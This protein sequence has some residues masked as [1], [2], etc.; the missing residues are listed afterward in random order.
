M[1]SG[2][3]LH[4]TACLN[5]TYH[6]RPPLSTVHSTRFFLV[7]TLPPSSLCL[8]PSTATAYRLYCRCSKI[9][10]QDS[11]RQ[12]SSVGRGQQ[13]LLKVDMS[14]QLLFIPHPICVCILHDYTQKV[15]LVRRTLLVF[16][17]FGELYKR[18]TWHVTVHA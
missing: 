4:T 6:H 1:H 7:F 8:K 3:V 10:A 12:L 17:L 13:C 9:G 14:A 2:D 18:R 11:E 15:R 5:L 16:L